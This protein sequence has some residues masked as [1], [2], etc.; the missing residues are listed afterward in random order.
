MR[1]CGSTR[2][3]ANWATCRSRNERYGDKRVRRPGVRGGAEHRARRVPHVCGR[4]H[5]VVRGQ[6]RR[7]AQARGQLFQRLA[8]EPAHHDDACAGGADGRD[9]HPHRGRGAAAREP[10][11]QVAGTALQ[12]LPARRQDLSAGAAHPRAVAAHRPASRSALGAGTLLRAVSGRGC[13]A[14]DA[15][16]DAQAVQA[17]QLRG[18]RVPQPL[19][20]LP[21]VPDRPLQRAVRGAGGSGGVRRIGTPRGVVPRRPQRPAGR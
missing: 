13:G 17:A 4:R 6:G 19:A 14:R 18:Q 3:A 11:D 7:A 2:S 10:A 5:A 8:E 9:R 16:P 20:A 21:A 1:S 15:E 12:R